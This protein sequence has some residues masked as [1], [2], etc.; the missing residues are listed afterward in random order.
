MRLRR[1]GVDAEYPGVG[2]GAAQHGA[3]Q[4]PGQH[5]VV[6]VLAAAPDEAG[7]FLALH[8]PVAARGL[9]GGVDL[10]REVL[11]A[12]LVDG[13]HAMASELSASLRVADSLAAAHCTERTMFS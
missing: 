3:V 1:A 12:L 9:A 10:D 4:H 5:H 6:D 8:R 7:V 2:Q 13:G 11:D